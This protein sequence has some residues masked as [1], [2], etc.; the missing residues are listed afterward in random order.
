MFPVQLLVI[1]SPPPVSDYSQYDFM[2]YGFA[3]P[4]ILHY[5]ICVKCVNLWDSNVFNS[6]GVGTFDNE[7]NY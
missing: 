6:S 3:F 2:H 1:P 5:D 4:R 7:K